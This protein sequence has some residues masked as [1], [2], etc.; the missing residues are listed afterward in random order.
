MSEK[1][2]GPFYELVKTPWGFAVWVGN[3]RIGNVQRLGEGRFMAD[4][5]YY[6]RAYMAARELVKTWKE[7][8]LTHE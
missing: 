1:A 4:G 7:R 5:Q 6:D 2:K 8:E 3:A